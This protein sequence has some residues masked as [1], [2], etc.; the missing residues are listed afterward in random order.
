MKDD[1]LT[2]LGETIAQLQ[3]KAGQSEANLEKATVETERL[4]KELQ[5]LVAF[6][7]EQLE[8]RDTKIS[9][10][11]KQIDESGD[12]ELS[13]R[14]AQPG[15]DESSGG[16]RARHHLPRISETSSIYFD[17]NSAFVKSE[18]IDFIKELAREVISSKGNVK[19][20]GFTHDE[21]SGEFNDQLSVRRAEAVREKLEQAGLDG[22]LVSVKGMGRDNEALGGESAWKARRVE[23]TVL[24]KAKAEAI[25]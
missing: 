23:I 21:G 24:P 22:S 2:S 9:L 13:D 4:G 7:A 1:E 3:E 15:G 14:V 8:E 6:H 10:L 5:R 25:N 20:V 11:E 12:S 17:S 18:S 19:I 16:G